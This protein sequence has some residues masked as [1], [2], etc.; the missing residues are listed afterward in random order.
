MLLGALGSS[1]MCVLSGCP[2]PPRTL[3]SAHLLL[4]VTQQIPAQCFFHLALLFVKTFS[5][6]FCCVHTSNSSYPFCCLPFPKGSN[7]EWRQV[8]HLLLELPGCATG[9]NGIFG[10]WW[11]MLT[12]LLHAEFGAYPSQRR[13]LVLYFSPK[14]PP[15]FTT[16]F[17]K[18]V[19]CPN[20]FYVYKNMKRSRL[21]VVAEMTE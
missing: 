19:A 2:P 17:L 20:E 7:P 13:G 9:Y 4:L 8:S 10:I 3:C 21:T 1:S 18:S 12:I 5:W 15:C 11:K 6:S 14:N 16:T